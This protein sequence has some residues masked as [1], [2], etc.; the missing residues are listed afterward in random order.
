MF[1]CRCKTLSVHLSLFPEPWPSLNTLSVLLIGPC[2]YSNK[3]WLS[4]SRTPETWALKVKQITINKTHLHTSFFGELLKCSTGKTAKSINMIVN[5]NQTYFTTKV[6]I[7]VTLKLFQCINL[8]VIHLL[9]IPQHGI[10]QCYN[11]NLN[12]HT[13]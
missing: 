11:Q 2:H 12:Y 4:H 5:E 6:K 9:I 13:I 7:K 1:T 3:T 10:K 8:P